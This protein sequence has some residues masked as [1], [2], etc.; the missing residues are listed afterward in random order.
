MHV[1]LSGVGR[2]DTAGAW[3]VERLLSAMRSRGVQ[4]EVTGASEAAGILLK[5]VEEAAR[6][7]GDSPPE[8]RRS[9]VLRVPR[10]RL[11]ASMYTIAGDAKASHVHPRRD[12][13]RRR[14]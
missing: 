5:A 6:R 11:D 14:R 12:D 2:I 7:D 1:D 9:F 13:P 10:G 4:P 3:L 8:P